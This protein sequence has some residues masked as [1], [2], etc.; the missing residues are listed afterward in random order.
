MWQR[1]CVV[2]RCAS[3]H[4]ALHTPHTAICVRARVRAAL[5]PW[6]S[7]MRSGGRTSCA[8]PASAKERGEAREEGEKRG[9]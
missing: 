8:L 1:I 5:E 4:F 9:A 2:S 3:R 7:P 6:P